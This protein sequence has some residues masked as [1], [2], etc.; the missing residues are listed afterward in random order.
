MISNALAS[1]PPVMSITELREIGREA[2]EAFRAD[3][4]STKQGRH[5]ETG[6]PYMETWAERYW[7]SQEA[8]ERNRL[9]KGFA[10]HRAHRDPLP[11]KKA[12]K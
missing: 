9:R 6:T 1:S 8:I 7:R 4:S 11:G 10:K 3:T 2:L 5:A 12:R